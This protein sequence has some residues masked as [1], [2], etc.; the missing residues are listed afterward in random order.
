MMF[1]GLKFTKVRNV[2]SRHANA[3]DKTEAGKP[4]PSNYCVFIAI[5]SIKADP[6]DTEAFWKEVDQTRDIIPCSGH[7]LTNKMYGQEKIIKRQS[8]KPIEVF[9]EGNRVQSYSLY[10]KETPV[11]LAYKG[12]VYKTTIRNEST[13]EE[14]ARFILLKS[15]S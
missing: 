14:Y 13:A 9:K 11:Y 2:V 10:I 1:D 8:S 15:E 3:H 12:L 4:I 7:S 6:S 5:Q